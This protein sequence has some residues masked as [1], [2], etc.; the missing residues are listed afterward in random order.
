MLAVALA[1]GALALGAVAAGPTP[2]PAPVAPG[3]IHQRDPG[4]GTLVVVQRADALIYRLP[5]TFLRAGSDSA[6]SR[7]GPWRRGADYL[8]EPLRGELRLLRPPLPGDT[9][10]VAA[11]WLL[12]PPALEWEMQRYRPARPPGAARQRRRGAARGPGSRR[13]SGDRPQSLRGAPAGAN[14]TV[15]GNKTIAVDFGSS[16]DAFLRQ[17]LDLAVSGTLA[18]GVQLTGVLSDRNLPLTSAGSTQDLQALDR[19]LIELTAPR[20]S[21]ALG[22]VPLSLAAGRVRTARPA[23]AGRARRVGGGWLPRDG[24]GGERPGR[25]PAR[26]VLR[27]R[28]PAGALPAPRPQRQR[29]RLGGGG[30]RGGDGGRRAHGPR[31]GGGLRDRLRAGAH[32]LHEPAAHHGDLA[33]HRGLPVHAQ[34]L[35]AESGGG[36]RALGVG[37]APPPHAG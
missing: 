9:L 5:R 8:I 21:A 6:W 34:S 25:V 30:Q 37:P 4:C 19:V 33:H 23:G 3:A 13:A 24:G 11:C 2:A 20:G 26:A 36:R 17:S 7:A 10:W 1:V 32:H 14:L 29:G 16:Q 27:L 31:R 22:D 35:P 28:G 15:N 18:P 12:A